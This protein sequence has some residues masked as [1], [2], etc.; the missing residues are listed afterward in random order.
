MYEAKD[1]MKNNMQHSSR[2]K[3][4]AQHLSLTGIPYFSAI[5]LAVLGNCCLVPFLTIP[6]N[7]CNN[8]SS[9]PG[10]RIY[11]RRD[12]LVL[13]LRELMSGGPSVGSVKIRPPLLSIF[14]NDN[15][16]I[17]TNATMTV[18]RVLSAILLL[19]KDLKMFCKLEDLFM[20]NFYY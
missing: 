11:S 7:I 16:I 13:L 8:P 18:R 9:F 5:S 17:Q 19:S 15:T 2:I 1:E 4:I 14:W 10:E 6:S 20:K 12:F 3:Q